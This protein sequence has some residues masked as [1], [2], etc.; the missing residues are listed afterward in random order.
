MAN[1]KKKLIIVVLLISSAVSFAFWHWNKKQETTAQQNLEAQRKALIRRT[2]VEVQKVGY[3]DITRH[4]VL[5]GTLEARNAAILTTEVQGR[6][7]DMPFVQG[8]YVKKG[9]LLVRID[10]VSYRA[11][12]K[13]AIARRALAK[14][15]YDRNQALKQKGFGADSSLDKAHA[16]LQIAEAD[17][18]KARIHL[19]RTEIRAPFNGYVGLQKVNEGISIGTFV[20]GREELV[21][22]VQV[23]EL[24][25]DFLI[26]ESVIPYVSMGQEIDFTVEGET[27]PL[28]ATILAIEPKAESSTHSLKVRAVFVNE[29]LKLKPGQFVQVHLHIQKKADQSLVIPFI[30]VSKEGDQN[31]VFTV[32]DNIAIKS[33]VILGEKS[34]SDMIEV[35][36]GLKEGDEIVVAG[37]TKISDGARVNVIKSDE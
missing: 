14:S 2:N 16:D 3:G 5:S 28:T 27:L 33:M 1:M 6:I 30:A 12:L 32:S 25:V 35:V 37:Q 29:K 19:A 4:M 23:D 31:Y 21:R 7:F 8:S 18:E 13:E 36:D 9:D 10:D 15:Q 17:V 34:G 26:P 11:A 20:S 22:L 24:Y